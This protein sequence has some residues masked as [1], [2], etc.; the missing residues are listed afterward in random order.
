MHG[1]AED[2]LWGILPARARLA[3]L[4]LVGV[5]RVECDI[6]RVGVGPGRADFG[7]GGVQCV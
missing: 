4:V 1:A 7:P 2:V 6:G 3:F 5:I